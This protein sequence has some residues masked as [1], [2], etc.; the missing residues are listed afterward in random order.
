[1]GREREGQ[2]EREAWKSRQG[3]ERRG[4]A[5]WARGGH[6]RHPSSQSAV[7]AGA[8]QGRVGVA[9]GAPILTLPSERGGYCCSPSR[10]RSFLPHL[11]ARQRPAAG[12]G[13][14]PPSC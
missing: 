3:E 6:C 7:Q 12:Q 9:A 11:C 10:T 2:T 8:S 1:M 13:T 4:G 5:G 14:L